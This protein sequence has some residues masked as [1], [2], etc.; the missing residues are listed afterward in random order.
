[1][2]ILLEMSSCKD[3]LRAHP[4]KDLYVPSGNSKIVHVL[5]ED[6]LTANVFGF[7]KN[8]DPSVWLS[9]I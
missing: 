6:V 4:I 1:M 7:L 5:S 3:G 2:T 9:S 8:L